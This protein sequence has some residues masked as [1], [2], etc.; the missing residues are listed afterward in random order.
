MGNESGLNEYLGSRLSEHVTEIVLFYIIFNSMVY[1]GKQYVTT[2]S[3]KLFV[4][5]RYSTFADSTSIEY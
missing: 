2:K 4:F 5:Y 3:V 1:E